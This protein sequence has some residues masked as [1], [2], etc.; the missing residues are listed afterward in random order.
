MNINRRWLA[1]LPILVAVTSCSFLLDTDGA[2]CR[3][4]GDCARFAGAVCDRKFDVCVA[5]PGG[6]GKGGSGGGL[7]APDASV[8]PRDATAEND[9]SALVR[10]TRPNKPTVTLQ[11]DIA[12][13]DM[14]SCDKDYRLVGNVFVK[15]GAT[16]TI[17]AGTTIRGDKE[18]KGTLIVQPGARLMAEGTR[19]LPIV[20]TSGV[21]VANRQAGDWGG[22]ILLGKAPVN[23]AKASI[24]GLLEGGEYGGTDPADSSGTL[25]YVRIEYSGTKIG[26]NNEINGLTLGGVGA[27]TLLDYIQVRITTDD[28]FEFFGGTVNAKHLLCQGNGDDGFDWDLGY[29]GKLQFL[30]LQQD[31]DVVDETNGFEG[32]NDAT[33]STKTPLSEPTIFNA[34]LCGKG[35]DVDKQ[36]YGLLLRRTTRGRFRNLI[37]YGFEAGFD[38]RDANTVVD[39]ASS[40]FFGNGTKNLAYEENGTDNE[41]QKDD[42]VGFDEIAYLS[43]PMRKISAQDPGLDCF[44]RSALRLGPNAALGEGAESPPSDGFFDPTAAFM[45]AFRDAN[46]A[47]ASGSW[48]VWQPR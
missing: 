6:G 22:V 29:R 33:G 9:A 27:G 7:A 25:K 5:A 44:N 13:S 17:E 42:D 45:G 34:T 47:W 28:C 39:V 20:F 32:D 1:I 40:V 24:E 18:T 26:P 4:D 23:E 11:G 41:A 2:Q 12:T 21:D 30:A 8:A 43:Q 35:R 16:L 36:Q 14:L 15:A 38:V 19:D 46:D 10:C 48:V 37:V 3:S 31:P